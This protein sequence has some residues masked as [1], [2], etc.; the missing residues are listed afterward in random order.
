MDTT[1]PNFSHAGS[2]RS[3]SDSLSILN[4]SISRVAW[5]HNQLEII[6]KGHNNHDWHLTFQAL[7]LFSIKKTWQKLLDILSFI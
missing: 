1:L 6:E 3:Q 7:Q 4:V 2:F 5:A